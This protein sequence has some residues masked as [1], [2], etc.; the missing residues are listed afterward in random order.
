MFRSGVGGDRRP[1]SG[2]VGVVV[3]VGV[4]NGGSGGGAPICTTDVGHYLKFLLSWFRF[5][6]SSRS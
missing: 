4:G 2:G 6:T 5:S 1:V 3:V